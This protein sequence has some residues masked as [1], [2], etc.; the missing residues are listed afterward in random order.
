[1]K[2]FLTARPAFRAACAPIVDTKGFTTGTRRCSLMWDISVQ[3]SWMAA[4]EAVN[5]MWIHLAH[6]GGEEPRRLQL[7][8]PIAKRLDF[9]CAIS[10][11]SQQARA[12]TLP[13]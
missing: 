12:D 11:P 13:R 7:V 2:I 8:L 5:S 3:S 1:M 4:A 10:G 6:S 9:D